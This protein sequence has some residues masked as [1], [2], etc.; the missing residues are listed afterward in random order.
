LPH[1]IARGPAGD[2]ATELVGECPGAID[3]DVGDANEPRRRDVPGD[4]AGMDRTHPAGAD[5]PEPDPCRHV[6]RP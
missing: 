4:R 2:R 3:I 5:Q 1:E 6:R